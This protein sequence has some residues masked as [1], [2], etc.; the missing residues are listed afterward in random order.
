M[1][2]MIAGAFIGAFIIIAGLAI[3]TMVGFGIIS[4]IALH[5]ALFLLLIALYLDMK[6]TLRIARKYR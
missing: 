3:T 5:P 1:L 6:M 2:K 4:M